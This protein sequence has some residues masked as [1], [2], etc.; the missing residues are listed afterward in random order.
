VTSPAPGRRRIPYWKTS[1]GFSWLPWKAQRGMSE[2]SIV[3]LN[4]SG[5]VV[6]RM[7]MREFM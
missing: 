3:S 6:S 7:L 2:V 4:P 1:A 5:V